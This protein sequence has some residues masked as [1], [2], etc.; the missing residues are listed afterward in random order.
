[1]VMRMDVFDAF[2]NSTSC[3]SVKEPH[4]LSCA[5]NEAQNKNKMGKR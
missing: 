1:M 3:E 2:E 4:A 5:D